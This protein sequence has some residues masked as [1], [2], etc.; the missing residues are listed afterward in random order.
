MATR[1]LSNIQWTRRERQSLVLGLLFISPWLINALFLQLYP[2]LASMYYSLTYY[3][4]LQ[5][6][7]FIGLEN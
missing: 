4:V 2:F 6:A 7:H 5:P 1:P 3:N